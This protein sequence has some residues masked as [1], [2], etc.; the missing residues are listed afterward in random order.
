MNVTR[1]V[2]IMIAWEDIGRLDILRMVGEGL[3]RGKGKLVYC[4]Q[5]GGMIDEEVEVPD[6]VESFLCCC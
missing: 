3:K 4:D 6:T 1:L 2:E 5:L